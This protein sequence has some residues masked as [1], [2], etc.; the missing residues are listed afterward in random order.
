MKGSSQGP[1]SVHA[2]RPIVYAH[3]LNDHSGSP[4]V[5]ASVISVLYARGVAGRLFVG[6]DGAG[7]LDEI[8]APITRYWYRR[9]PRPVLTLATY[10][11]SQLCLLAKLLADR[12]IDRSAVIYVN[13]LLPFGA[14]I[15]GWLTG[16][17]VVYHLHEVS[18]RPPLLQ[19]LLVSIARLTADRLIYVS[20]FHRARLP[21]HSVSATTVYNML[22]P[23]LA[24]R[25]AA[26]AYQHRRDGSFRVLMLSSLRD[27][28]GVPEFIRLAGDLGFREDIS[29]ELV[30]NDDDHSAQRYL[31]A[32]QVPPALT[33]HSRT[34]DPARHYERASLVVNL[35]RPDACIE[36]F[37]L[38][39]LEAMAFGIPVIAPPTGGPLELVDDGK[40]GFLLDSRDAKALA[41]RVVILADTPQLCEAMSA[42]AREKASLFSEEAFAESLQAALAAELA[43]QPGGPGHAG[44]A[45]PTTKGAHR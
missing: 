16:R 17:R 32:H 2:S 13:T 21:I 4:K 41:A 5:L 34:P 24:E 38:T 33:I 37:G 1:A 26:S 44:A 9:T 11:T 10:M 30:C 28:K 20:N 22:S 18:L 40:E 31:S 36:T 7:C 43:T 39:V 45:L 27:Y 42:A 12:R 35:S 3:L 14:A 15:Y 19:W 6:S 29:F 8:E 23:A 25:A